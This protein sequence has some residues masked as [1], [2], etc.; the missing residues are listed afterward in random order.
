VDSS[1]LF[2]VWCMLLSFTFTIP[3]A[4]RVVRKNT[5]E[6]LAILG[7]A[8]GFSGS[9]M[10]VVYGIAS[11]KPFIS[12]GNLMT[13]LG[14]GVVLVQMTRFNVLPK[15][16]LALLIAVVYGFALVMQGISLTV[17][18]AV[19]GVVGSTGIVPQVWK[20]ARESHLKGVSVSGNLLLALTTVSWGTYGLMIEDG[21]LAAGNYAVVLPALFIAF[22]AVQS[23]RRFGDMTTEE[24]VST[25]G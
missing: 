22:R 6:G 11:S 19:A 15:Q 10:W 2:T 13:V 12:A 17:L 16:R 8:Q 23:H 3:Q 18:G 21:L 24:L 9:S 14:I 20:A 7:Q 4:W 25:R 5:V 1:D